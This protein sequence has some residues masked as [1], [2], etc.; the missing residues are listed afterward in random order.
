[1]HNEREPGSTGQRSVVIP[2]AAPRAIEWAAEEIARGGVV[3]I[4]TD[5]VYGLVASLAHADAIDRIYELKGRPGEQPLP[6][7]VA[8]I[9]ALEHVTSYVDDRVQM[10]LNEFWPGPL[11][12]VIPSDRNLPRAVLGPGNTVGVRIPNHPLAIEV[13]GKAGGA[14]ASSSANRSSE[15]PASTAADVEATFGAELDLILEG[16]IAPGG[17]AST[18]VAIRGG[19]LKILREGPIDESELQSAWDNYPTSV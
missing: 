1:M 6:V 8:S 13:I 18:V 16:G 7:L 5:T 12:V 4:P 14:V 10:L 17:R 11:T 15:A 19:T 9:D 3:A 2:S